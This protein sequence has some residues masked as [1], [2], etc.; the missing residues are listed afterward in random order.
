MQWNT[1][2]QILIHFGMKMWHKFR[3]DNMNFTGVY[4]KLSSVCGKKAIFS[5]EKKLWQTMIRTELFTSVDCRC[6]K[7]ADFYGSQKD[8]DFFC[9]SEPR[10]I[11]RQVCEMPCPGQCV[12]SDWSRWSECPRVSFQSPGLIFSLLFGVN[13][14]VWFNCNEMHVICSQKYSTQMFRHEQLQPVVTHIVINLITSCLTLD[15][16]SSL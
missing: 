14:A 12:V 16:P 11:G 9:R 10:P 6:V 3:D 15:Y 13:T 1:K 8:S 2:N 7:K 4:T 5:L